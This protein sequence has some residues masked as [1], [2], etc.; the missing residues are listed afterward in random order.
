MSHPGISK[1]EYDKL[2]KMPLQEIRHTGAKL[3]DENHPDALWGP[4][5]AKRRK[6]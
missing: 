4:A 2:E 3:L 1:K 6:P 5:I